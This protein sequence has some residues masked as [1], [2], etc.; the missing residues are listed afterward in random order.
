MTVLLT[1]LAPHFSPV[2]ATH[3]GDGKWKV[4]VKALGYGK[5]DSEV[6]SFDY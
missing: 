4:K 3:T 2:D 5:E 6:I 1:I